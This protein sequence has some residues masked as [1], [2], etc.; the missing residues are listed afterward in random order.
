MESPSQIT[1]PLT[2]TTKKRR[3]ESFWGAHPGFLV[4]ASSQTTSSSGLK[5][6]TLSHHVLKSGTQELGCLAPGLAGGCS[7]EV[8]GGRTGVEDPQASPPTRSQ[9]AASGPP[10]GIA[11]WGCV[12][13]SACG[14]WPPG[15][16]V[17]A[18]EEAAARPNLRQSSTR[19]GC[20]KCVTGKPALK[21]SQTPPAK[22]RD[23][24]NLWA[25]FKTTSD[26]LP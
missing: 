8:G 19:S 18:G 11:P 2:T 12:G 25:S 7:R 6:H 3:W 21:R 15:R 17:R 22:T 26:G 14:G 1:L 13:T 10:P 5:H 4:W 9:Q 23:V 20:Q 24:K 16:A